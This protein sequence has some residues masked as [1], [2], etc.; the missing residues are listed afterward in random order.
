LWQYKHM[1]NKIDLSAP[2]TKTLTALQWVM[3]R[4]ALEDKMEELD[5][6]AE[7]AESKEY[8]SGT[9]YRNEYA[10]RS[11]ILKAIA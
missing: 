11:A 8:D 3:I 4:Q 2:E 5:N 7:W 9:Y 10:K 6:A 1:E